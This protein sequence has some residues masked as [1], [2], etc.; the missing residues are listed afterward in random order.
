MDLRWLS[1]L[2]H[3]LIRREAERCDRVLI[4]DEG[5]RSGGV[6]EALMAAVIEGTAG[7]VRVSRV[8]GEDCF[9]PLGD[10]ANAVL[11]G[12]DDIVEA[13]LRD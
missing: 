3:G 2:D 6:G 9:I 10:A 1:P 7:S 5:R 4:V 13:A 11:L 12:E 8:T